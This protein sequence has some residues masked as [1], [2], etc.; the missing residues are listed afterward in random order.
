MSIYRGQFVNITGRNT[1]QTFA[2]A[3]H[4]KNLA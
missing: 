3:T 2:Y 1:A 4:Q